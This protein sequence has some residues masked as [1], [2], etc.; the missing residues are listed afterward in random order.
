MSS[1]K[2]K[3]SIAVFKFASCDGC[4]LS[5]LDLEDELLDVVGA[6]DL[7]YFPEASSNM[8]KGPLRHRPGGRFHHHPPRRREDP[9]GAPPVQD[10]D[11]LGRVRHGRRHPGAAQLEG[12]RR[13]C[14][15]G[16][17]QT[18]FHQHAETVYADC[19]ARAGRLRAARLPDTEIPLGGVDQRRSGGPQ[20][21]SAFLQRLHGVQAERESVHCSWRR[22]SPCMGPVTLR[23]LRSSLPFVRP[24]VFRLLRPDGKHQHAVRWWSQF[25]ILGQS[26]EAIQRQFRNFNAWAWQFRQASEEVVRR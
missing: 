4:Q 2:A 16:V 12:C 10:A 24:W 8:R 11:H 6:V 3:P 18:R 19:R 22:A 14:P 23:G 9:A 25:R 20:A 13:V 1:R 5:L 21:E 7:A 15:P 17:R 26:D